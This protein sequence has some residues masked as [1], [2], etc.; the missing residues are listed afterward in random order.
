MKER[1]RMLSLNESLNLNE[2]F[3]G[4]KKPR[5]I[6]DGMDSEFAIAD[7]IE[8]LKEIVRAGYHKG[9]KQNVVSK[10]IKDLEGVHDPN[11]MDPDYY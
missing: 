7:A 1:D 4:V 2:F 6:K 11:R 8:T 3:M 9:P 5:K 10:C